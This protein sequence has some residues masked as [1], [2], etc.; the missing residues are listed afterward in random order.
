MKSITLLLC[1]VLVIG[2]GFA[3]AQTHY[4]VSSS[5]GKD[6]NKGKSIDKPWASLERVYR[7]KL[8]PGD[9]VAFKSGDVFNGQL[10]IDESGSEAAPIHFTAYGEGELPLIDGAKG[11]AGSPLAAILII[12]QDHIELSRLKI[13]NVRKK[14]LDGIADVNAYGVLVKNTGERNLRGFNFHHLVVE[15]IYPIRAKKSF[16]QTSVTGIR[17]ETRPAQ[18]KKRAFNTGDIYI[19]NNTLRHTARFGIALRHKP[20]KL[21]GVTGT[22]SDYDLDVRIINNHCEDLGG[23]CVLMNGVWRGLLE[24]NRFIRSGALVEPKLSVNRGSGAW[25]F[26]S[27]HIVAQHN[28]AIGSRGHNDSAGIH[29]DFANDNILVQYNFSYDNEGYGTEILGKNTN[30]IWRHNISVGDATRRMNVIRP[31]GGK[32]NYPGKTVF[33]SDFAVPKRVLSKDVF[34][35][36]NTYVITKGSDPLVELNGEDVHLWNNLFVVEEG[37][38]LGRKFNIGWTHGEPVDMQGNVFAGNISPNFI[39]IDASPLTT[40]LQFDGDPKDPASF[41]LRD[42]D[43]LDD[44]IVIQHPEFPAAGKGIFSHISAVPQV[45]YFG[46]KLNAEAAL[47]GAGVTPAAIDR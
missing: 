43:Q 23:S 41:A 5:T 9:T 12:D 14:P 34:I 36:N 8:K 37:A 28:I 33:V 19:H 38:R 32:S 10:E 4:Y 21:D 35:Y 20:S 22:E 46:N 42:T 27:N 29:V 31:E 3:H 39:A 1:A 16:N 17:F 13:H 44:G 18:W 15:E 26:R 25:F 24:G 40:A 11:K 47:I 7:A 6:S 30:I 45:D 2:S